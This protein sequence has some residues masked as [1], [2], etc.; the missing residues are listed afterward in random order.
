[1]ADDGRWAHQLNDYF[2][3]H[4]FSDNPLAD[5]IPHAISTALNI[6]LRSVNNEGEAM[7][8]NV[9]NE[10]SNKKGVRQH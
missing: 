3:R 2:V 10:E 4:L 9:F 1:M 5:V 6:M 8:C 7:Y